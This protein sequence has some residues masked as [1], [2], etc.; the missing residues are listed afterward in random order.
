MGL[1]SHKTWLLAA[2][3]IGLIALTNGCS[4]AQKYTVQP[5]DT[6]QKIALENSITVSQLVDANKERY[7]ALESNPRN[8]RSGME[9][10][11]PSEDD[12]SLQVE[13]W[14]VTALR[15]ASPPVTPSPSVPAAPNEKINA[16][17]ELIQQ[18][19]NSERAAQRLRPLTLDASLVDFAQL[20]SNDMITRQYF[21]H[22]D[23]KTGGVMFQ[24]LIRSSG[25]SYLFAG[26][27]IAEIRN[28][29]TFVPT[30]LTVYSRYSAGE[31]ADQFVE[32]WISSPEH[33]ENI[34]NPHFRRTGIALGVSVDGT[35]VVATQL[36]SD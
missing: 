14:F 17:V 9:L 1:H 34:V 2:L 7:P 23:P 25:Y 24:N 4:A 13:E 22:T 27:N 11:I 3:F 10:V 18:G 19:I 8:L 32:G 35:R 28:Q 5:G 26:E 31:L 15:A 33:Y 20:R 16:V 30:G 36:F 29:G 12:V 6:L 21:S